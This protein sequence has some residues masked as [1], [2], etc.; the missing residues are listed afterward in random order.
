MKLRIRDGRPF[1]PCGPAD[2]GQRYHKRRDV[3]ISILR[4]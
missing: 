1:P 4:T 3:R 2:D